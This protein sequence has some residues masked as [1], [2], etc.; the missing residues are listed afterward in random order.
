MSI[1]ARSYPQGNGH[2]SKD[3][4]LC[5]WHKGC[6]DGFTSAWIVWR[7]FNGHVEFHE[8]VYDEPPPDVEG[9]NVLIVDF[10]YPASVMTRLEDKAQAILILDHHKTAEAALRPWIKPLPMLTPSLPTEGCVA[11]FDMA[12]SGAGMTWDYFYGSV[13]QLAR[14]R[15]VN[16]VEDR[17]LW[18]FQILGTREIGAVLYSHPFDFNVWE[19]L[20][21]EMEDDA[22]YNALQVQGHA[23]DRAHLKHCHQLIKET[24]RTIRIGGRR[25]TVCNAPY[26]MASDIG[27]ILSTGGDGVGGT[28]YD[29]ANGK[30]I[31]SLRSAGEVD[32]SEIARL[33][34]GGGH[35]A[36]A[37]FTAPFPNWQGEEG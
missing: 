36:A 1:D 19:S 2:P 6:V 18:K 20:A 34:G 32:V 4:P 13:H 12:R 25:F 24:R 8:G 22:N 27:N 37:G 21:L 16:H 29:H 10:S 33:Y 5:I 23:I 30:R 31:F 17:D 7:Y 14:P 35:R 15:L 11:H 3:V 9:R 28:Y 26:F